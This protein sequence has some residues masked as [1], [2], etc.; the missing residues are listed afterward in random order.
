MSSFLAFAIGAVLPLIPWFITEGATA[1]VASVVVGLTAAA[2]VG[3]TLARFTERSPLRT[4][5]RQ[6]GWAAGACLV[7]YVIGELLGTQV[8]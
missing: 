7:T 6:V 2:A 1:M 8:S 3:V 5:L 4:A